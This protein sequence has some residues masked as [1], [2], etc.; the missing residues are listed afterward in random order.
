MILGIYGAG[1]AG[2][3]VKEIAEELGQWSEMIFIDDTVPADIYKGIRR[4]PFEEFKSECTPMNA[5]IV[6]AL[7]EPKHK[8][9]L[10]NKVK[11][12]GFSF[13][14]VIHSTAWI[15]PSSQIGK[16]VVL[17]AGVRI[18]ADSVIGD[19]VTIQEYSCVGHDVVI[20]NHSQ[21]AGFVIIGGHTTIGEATYIGLSVP[22]KDG[23]NIGSHSIVGMGSVVTR[24]IPDNVIAMGNPAR[25]MCQCDDNTR[26]FK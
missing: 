18:N 22:V 6:I 26:V 3:E 17:R 11:E 13:A 5:E 12:A 20:E 24:D 4:M 25:G 14:N 19:N 7:G 8:I 23:S 1:G 21:I 10:Y 2:K 16:G 9:T 15:S